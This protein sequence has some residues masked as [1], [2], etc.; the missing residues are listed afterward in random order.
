MWKWLG[1]EFDYLT[2]DDSNDWTNCISYLYA[3]TH[4]C[5]YFV[6]I[7][8]LLFYGIFCFAEYVAYIDN[9]SRNHSMIVRCRYNITIIAIDDIHLCW[10][11]HTSSFQFIWW[12]HGFL[13][14][15]YRKLA[16]FRKNIN[17]TSCLVFWSMFSLRLVNLNLYVVV[18]HHSLSISP[19]AIELFRFITVKLTLYLH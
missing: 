14:K 7:C 12:C 10:G 13:E 19:S 8:Q 4:R 15:D 5:D 11:M 18:F 16:G 17:Q 9:F 6:S 2:S 1:I 3:Q